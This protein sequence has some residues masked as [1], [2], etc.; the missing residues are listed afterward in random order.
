MFEEWLALHQVLGGKLNK[1]L[2]LWLLVH[3]KILF[4]LGLTPNK[5]V[6][7]AC[8]KVCKQSREDA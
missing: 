6:G 4:G 1:C 5:N 2:G 8:Q 3:L 7:M